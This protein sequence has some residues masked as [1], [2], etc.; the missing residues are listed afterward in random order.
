MGFNMTP[1]KLGSFGLS[2]FFE[3]FF[4]L[5]GPRGAQQKKLQNSDSDVMMATQYNAHLQFYC[6]SCVNGLASE[7]PINNE[8]AYNASNCKFCCF[9]NCR[10]N[11]IV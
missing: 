10:F 4:I 3:G 11:N 7:P 1:S 2:P 5:D 8:V 9:K 6:S